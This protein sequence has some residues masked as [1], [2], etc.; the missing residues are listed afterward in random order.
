DG[1]PAPLASPPP[2]FDEVQQGLQRPIADPLLAQVRHQVLQVVG[3]APG[4]PGRARDQLGLPLE[5][6]RAR[7]LRMARVGEEAQR[8]RPSAG[9]PRRLGLYLPFAA[10]ALA[11][12]LWSAF[13]VIASGQIAVR[14][15]H[16]KAGLADAGYRLSWKDRRIGGYPFRMDVTL[17]EVAVREPSGWA[18]AAPRLEAEA[19][20]YALGQ[21]LV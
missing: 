19:P 14:L 3:V 11:I 7:P 18:L 16:A 2:R 6:E 12:A 9:K 4:K 21:W 15:D 13:W 5:A 20:A 17:T 10:L 8:L 1:P